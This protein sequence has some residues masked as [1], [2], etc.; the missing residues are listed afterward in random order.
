MD[1]RLESEYNN[2]P[3][4]SARWKKPKILSV[5]NYLLKL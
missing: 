5:E 1:L 4:E 2:E 3:K